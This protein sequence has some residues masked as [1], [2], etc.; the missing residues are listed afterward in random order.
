M[1]GS[2]YLTLDTLQQ[3]SIEEAVEQA[4]SIVKK[5]GVSVAFELDGIDVYITSQ[6]N[7][8]VEIGH[9]KERRDKRD[10]LTVDF[11]FNNL[12]VFSQGYQSFKLGIEKEMNPYKNRKFQ[13]NGWRE[14]EWED[15]WNQAAF[16]A[17]PAEDMT[18]ANG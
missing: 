1:M 14:K 15:G 5:L 6:S 2:L 18:H 16:E 9:F 13:F 10:V 3:A 17:T 11:T 7:P 8:Q 12:Q 4:Q